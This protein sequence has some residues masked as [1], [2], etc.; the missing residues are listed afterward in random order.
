MPTSDTQVT[1]STNPLEPGSLSSTER[2]QSTAKCRSPLT[3]EEWANMKKPKILLVGAG[4]GGSTM[5]MGSN[6]A[7]LF[8]Q[9]D[10]LDEF[11]EIGKH[12]NRKQVFDENLKPIYG[13]PSPSAKKYLYDL[14]LR[15]IPKEKI[16]MN[17]KVLSILQNDL[18]VMIRCHDGSTHH[19][20]IFVGA[21]GAYS[22]VRRQLY[23]DLKD[24]K[25]LL[26]SDKVP[27]SFSCVCLAD[28][29]E[30]LDPEEFPDLNLPES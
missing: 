21:D 3:G 24:K 7:S 9:I 11:K 2:C 20:D 1:A 29:T 22:A 18:G 8:S 23:K 5:S 14:L 15:Q 16:N 26:K 27:L 12:M 25:K 17:Q 6:L 28:Q 10:I 30:V 19:G 4:I 13:M